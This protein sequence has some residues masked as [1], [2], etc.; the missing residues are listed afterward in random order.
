MQAAT[1]AVLAQACNT[2]TLASRNCT[3]DFSELPRQSQA[4]QCT[5]TIKALTEAI[6]TE[7]S[8][9][10]PLPPPAAF[11]KLNITAARHSVQSLPNSA[12][13]V[14]PCTA[15]AISGSRESS[16]AAMRSRD[17][18]QLCMQRNNAK[19]ASCA[20]K[21]EMQDSYPCKAT[22]QASC[23]C[24]AGMQASSA[25]KAGMQASSACRAAKPVT[26]AE[27]YVQVVSAALLRTD[28]QIDTRHDLRSPFHCRLFH[29]SK[30]GDLPRSGLSSPGRCTLAL[31]A[32]HARP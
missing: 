31:L 32:A 11:C 1:Q 19:Q 6:I 29:K 25:C 28:Q 13:Q 27:L 17:A 30:E 12:M 10:C 3:N 5:A 8:R 4:M 26:S 14:M 7:S 24:K 22:M 21:A 9:R 20:C 16:N 23:A 18:G 2:L 15:L